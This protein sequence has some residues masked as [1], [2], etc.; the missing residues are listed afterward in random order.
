MFQSCMHCK[1]TAKLPPNRRVS[2]STLTCALNEVNCID[3]VSFDSITVYHMMD[4]ISRLSSSLIVRPTIM[5]ASIYAPEMCWFSDIWLLTAIRADH[6]LNNPVFT[7]FLDQYDIK[8]GSVP[9]QRY[10]TSIKLR[11]RTIRAI[12]FC[13]KIN[14]ATVQDAINAISAVRIYIGIYWWKTLFAFETRK[15]FSKLLLAISVPVL[16]DEELQDAHNAL[17]TDPELTIIR[18]SR[19]Y[20]S[21]FSKLDT[22]FR[23]SLNKV[24]R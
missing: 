17:I 5:N 22:L 7:A 6:S 4:V 21:Q 15:G 16:I 10:K 18:R 13:L 11:H 12:C 1:T 9:S 3:H 24:A 20:S 14:D 8:F 2:F 19:T 23:F